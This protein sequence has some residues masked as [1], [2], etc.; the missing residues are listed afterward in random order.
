M[1]ILLTEEEKALR[2]EIREFSE[3]VLKPKADE[4]DKNGFDRAHYDKL[5]KAGYTKYETSKDYGGAG[6]LAR[7]LVIEEISR[8][9][10]GV[11]LSYLVGGMG[12]YPGKANEEMMEKFF[13]PWL[14]G[15][16][17]PAF[18]L[19][20]RGAGSDVSS[21]KTTA[22]S[23]GDYYVIN[24]TKTLIVNGASADVVNVYA[25]TDTSVPASKGMSMIAVP[26]GTPGMIGKPQEMFSLRGAEVADIEFVNCRVPKKNLIGEEG[27]GFKYAMSGI[28]GGRINAAASA[29]GIAQH[30]LDDA[31]AYAKE[32][33]QFGKPI[34]ANQGLNWYLAEMKAKLESSRALVY[35][36]ARMLDAADPE[37]ETF[38]ALAKLEASENSMYIA[39]L[40]LKIHGGIGCTKEVEAERIFRDAHA[41]RIYDGTSEILKLVVARTLTK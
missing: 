14:K 15:E 39:D 27:M 31:V 8:V 21:V 40:N 18:A 2:N 12:M 20:E 22:E 28:A 37:A 6:T 7:L 1:N 17:L 25:L 30:A 10:P 36:A 19:T 33:V 29:V 38:A 35:E 4:L 3:K 41:A 24:G 9:D 13:Y 34:G 23:D 16:I 5:I 32:R 26:K 11:A